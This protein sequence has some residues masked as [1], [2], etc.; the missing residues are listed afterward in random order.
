MKDLTDKMR[1][2]LGSIDKL[3]ADP[4]Y[5]RRNKDVVMLPVAAL[6][7]LPDNSLIPP[8][9]SDDYQNLYES[10]RKEGIIRTPCHVS[11]DNVV[12]CGNNRLKIAKEL[13]LAEVPA[14]VVDVAPEQYF[15]Y[16]LEDNLFRRQLNDAQK[17]ELILLLK[18]E[19]QKQQL[20]NKAA[21]FEKDETKRVEINTLG[22]TTNILAKKVGISPD[23]LVKSEKIKK[24]N[25]NLFAQVKNGRVSVNSAYQQIRKRKEPE[26][27]CAGI[28][29]LTANPEKRQ[30]T[31]I[32]HDDK[33]YQIVEAAIRETVARYSTG[34]TVT[35]GTP[36]TTAEGGSL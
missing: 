8:L 9:T 14:I 35:E 34:R 1:E 30:I 23:T 11:K 18:P 33:T 29:R 25:P 7:E 15:F 28:K 17:A 26:T 3:N 6:K 13:G 27:G 12:L 21:N 36:S 22:R 31:V 20:K 24:E 19:I 2:Q 5:E 32:C 16:A 4:G 10:I